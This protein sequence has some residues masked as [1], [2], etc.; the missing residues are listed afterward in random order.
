MSSSMS[1]PK[2]VSSDKIYQQQEI[3]Y[4]VDGIVE[5]A[6]TNS[7]DSSSDSSYGS[8]N[9]NDDNNSMDRI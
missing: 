4:L 5:S 3:K 7:S 6:E 1:K 2:N 9:D 8:G